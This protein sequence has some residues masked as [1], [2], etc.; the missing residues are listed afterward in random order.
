MT[1]LLTDSFIKESCGQLAYNKG[2]NL[3]RTGKTALIHGSQV[4]N[5][6]TFDVFDDTGRNHIHIALNSDSVSASCPCSLLLAFDKH[7]KHVA[8]ALF[9]LREMLQNDSL[10]AAEQAEKTNTG[11]DALLNDIVKLFSPQRMLPSAAGTF[12]EQRAMLTVAWVCKPVLQNY[13]EQMFALELKIGLKRLY[14]VSDASGFLRRL[15]RRESCY[16]AKSFTY[17]PEL[18]C[19]HP[20]D[21]A[22]L[23]KLCELLQQDR[24]YSQDAQSRYA[25][26]GL[27]ERQLPISPAAW[28]ELLPLLLKAPSIRLEEEHAVYDGLR[29]ST[30]PLPLRFEFDHADSVSVPD[31]SR[32]MLAVSGME[33]I[34]VMEAYNTVISNGQL[35]QLPAEQCKRLYELKRMLAAGE[36]DRL[37]ISGQMIGAFIEKVVPGLLKLGRVEISKAVSAKIVQAPL[38]AKLFLDRVKERLLAALE[39]HYGAIVI[40][41]LESGDSPKHGEGRILIRDDEGENTII[42]LMEQLPFTKT[43]SGYF[44]H[45]EAAEF[46]FLHTIIPQLEKLLTVYATT[47]VKERLYVGP[48]PISIKVEVDERTDWLELRFNMEEISEAE[49][50]RLLQAI[51]VKRRYYRLPSGALLPLEGDELQHIIRLLN[52]IGIRALDVAGATMRLPIRHALALNPGQQYGQTAQLSRN[53]R[54]L[55]HDLHNPDNLD[56]PLPAPFDSVLRDYQKYGYQW[57]RT[58]AHYHFGGI[59]ADDM[60]LGKTVQSIAFLAAMQEEIREARQPALIVAPSSLIYNWREELQ[61]FAPGLHAVVIDGSKAERTRSWLAAASAD[62]IITSYPLLRKDIKSCMN[63]S[64]HTLLLDEAQMFKNDM[65]QTAKAVKLLQAKYRFAL[66]GTPIENALT[67]LWSIYDAVFPGLFPGRRE[68]G[69]LSRETIA[70]QIR[71]FLLRRLKRDVLKE[72]PEK[73]ESTQTMPLLPEQ[74]KL[75]IAYL[76]KLRQETLKHLDDDDYQQNRLKILAGLTRLRQLCCHPALFVDG[77]KGSSAKFEQLMELLEECRGSGRRVL[78]FSQ[79]TEMLN[80]IRRELGQRGYPFF[81][82]DGQTPS[83]ERVKLCHRFNNGERD[84][85]LISLKAGGTGLNLTGADT[86][87][88]YDLWW[89]PAVEQ[90]AEDRAHRIGQQKRVQI[91][92][93]IAKDTVEEKMYALQQRKKGLIDEVI[94][95]GHTALSALSEQDI[96]ELLALQ[97]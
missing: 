64:F 8:A 13:R 48:P 45:D 67:E 50:R 2:K 57:L 19:F 25:N 91:V 29:L 86:V 5:D 80:I 30:E 95:P 89:N 39:F 54:R 23:A 14:S 27:T 21:D 7:C 52:D 60:G 24:L 82:L 74:K 37:L 88:L 28:P 3:Y 96:R 36:R 40:N 10:P 61:K 83:P 6:Y 75:Y 69:E 51:E 46:E 97:N 34:T 84:L 16:F 44:L 35:Q 41:P 81:Y 4:T 63:M 22:I 78:L 58:L 18:H 93:L 68:F 59:L 20:D 70:K 1:F 92:R 38:K 76:A 56:F 15:Q 43:E 17:E 66:T 12:F 62:I 85:F 71:P 65:T 55:L 49:I 47:A 77:Y 94:E 11:D 33:Q 72:L 9:S 31:S 87:I 32:Y 42:R 79:F 26:W 53:L 90:Q 73:I